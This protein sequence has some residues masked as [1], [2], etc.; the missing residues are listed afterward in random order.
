MISMMTIQISSFICTLHVRLYFLHFIFTG[1]ANEGKR[2]LRLS[3]EL[4]AKQ[5]Q[6]SCVWARKSALKW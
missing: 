1:N 4:L 6:L 2:K 5:S 3:I